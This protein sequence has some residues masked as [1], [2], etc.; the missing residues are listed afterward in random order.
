MN[1]RTQ[2]P[3]ADL[4]R[5]ARKAAIDSAL[6]AVEIAGAAVSFAVDSLIPAVEA[7]AALANF[8]GMDG[9]AVRIRMALIQKLA[10]VAI[11]LA[12]DMD[13]CMSGYS[14]SAKDKLDTL[15][16]RAA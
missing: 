12:S 11:G 10:G 9:P 1:A 6:M 15:Q 8:E 3:A 4:L 16:A 14:S 5:D 2:D 7:I 13:G